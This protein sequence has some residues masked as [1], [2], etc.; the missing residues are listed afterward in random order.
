M[1]FAGLAQWE[2]TEPGLEPSSMEAKSGLLTLTPAACH[3]AR[4]SQ[5]RGCLPD[6]GVGVKRLGG[7]GRHL[8][9]PAGSSV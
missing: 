8:L 1:W 2:V 5:W 4:D 7:G 9:I 6:L 3:V